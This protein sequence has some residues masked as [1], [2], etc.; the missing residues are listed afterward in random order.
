M[1]TEAEEGVVTD[2]DVSADVDATVTGGDE[3]TASGAETEQESDEVVIAIDGVTPTQEDEEHKAPDW[4]RDLRKANR[5]KDRRIRELE[6]KVSTP[7]AQAQ[8]VTLGQKPTLSDCDYDADE[9]ANKLEGWYA[10]KR[11]VEE[12][13]RGKQAEA[14][15]A[16][17]V[18]QAKLNDYGKAKQAL[19]VRDYDDAEAVAQDTL[20]VTQQGV[21]LSGSDNPAQVIYVL[22]KNPA[23]AKELAAIT[24]PVKFAFAIAKLETKLTVTP[25]KAAPPPEKTVRGSAPSTGAVD[26]TL[27]RLRAEAMK[28]GDLT[29]V[30]QYQR[31]QRA[32]AA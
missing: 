5:E 18:W 12:A 16:Q 20:S 30:R 3:S 9:Y 21:I 29:K 4:V 15:K 13:E 8:P 11:E 27:E 31:S 32:K 25:K 22:G 1:A 17:D 28:T 7:A 26:Q 19:K 24:D 14:K 6:A 2:V 23:K 10:K